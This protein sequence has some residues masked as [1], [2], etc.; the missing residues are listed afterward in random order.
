MIQQTRKLSSAI[1]LREVLPSEYQRWGT[2]LTRDKLTTVY[3]LCAKGIQIKPVLKSQCLAPGESVY[4]IVHKK[5]RFDTRTDT[6]KP[7]E[8]T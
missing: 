5:L 3:K 6:H 1:D 8:T 4:V 2:P 7:N